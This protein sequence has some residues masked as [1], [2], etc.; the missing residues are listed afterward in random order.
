M[1]IPTCSKI[2]STRAEGTISLA[3]TIIG[4][5]HELGV[6]NERTTMLKI[7]LHLFI[8]AV[9]VNQKQEA[10][11]LYNTL[12]A[13]IEMIDKLKLSDP[14]ENEEWLN[15]INVAL[16][17]TKAYFFYK[18]K[19]GKYANIDHIHVSEEQ[20]RFHS[21]EKILK[22][23]CNKLLEQMSSNFDV[24]RASVALLISKTKMSYSKQEKLK[25]Q[26]ETEL[27]KCFKHLCRQK[28][29]EAGT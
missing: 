27:K 4:K 12:F 17:F 8:M 21:V 2:Y 11:T 23:N 13:E 18:L 9:A 19:R 24:Q 6:V 26:L 20:K 25:G 28:L 16:N 1:A 22:Y 10:E 29:Q 15:G 7:K 5:V 14:P 3:S